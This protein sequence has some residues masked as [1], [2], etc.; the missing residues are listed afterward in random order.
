MNLMRSSE[1][2]MALQR[3]CKIGSCSLLLW[4]RSVW[5]IEKGRYL[6]LGQFL[7]RELV[8]NV[9]KQHSRQLQE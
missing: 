6:S 8:M 9:E 3:H 7:R 2:G 1:V 5:N 4:K